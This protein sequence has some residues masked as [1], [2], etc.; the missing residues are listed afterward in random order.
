M[1]KLTALTCLLITTACVN[2]N[3]ETR[4]F[5]AINLDQTKENRSGQTLL[6]EQFSNL[7]LSN[8]HGAENLIKAAQTKEWQPAS[9][10][11]LNNAGL[12]KLKKTTL[13]IPGGGSPVEETQSIFIKSFKD[14]TIV[15]V[16]SERFDRKKLTVTNCALYGKQVGFLKNCTGLGKVINRAPDQNTKYGKSKAHFISWNASI[17]QK[18]ARIKCEHTPQNPTL[19]YEGT[20]LIASVDYVT[21]LKSVSARKSSQRR[22]DV[23]ER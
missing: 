16:I 3:Q 21:P 13:K 2:G 23:S 12:A 6:V 17:S 22:F 9:R 19:S 15:W 8:A 7:C 10:K 4:S 14:Q 11:D 5:Q 20:Q 1:K 18:R